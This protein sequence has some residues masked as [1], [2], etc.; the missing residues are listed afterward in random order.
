MPS[1]PPEV[2]IVVPARNAAPTLEG[3]LES[4]VAQTFGSWEAI[5]IDD[6]ST[7]AT[8]SLAGRYARGD[9][10]FSILPGPVRNLGSARNA[11][12]GKAAGRFLLFLDADDTIEPD[13]LA[14][15][16]EQLRLRSEADV[17]CWRMEI[18][19]GESHDFSRA[20]G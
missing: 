6:G 1:P 7:D 10:R 15:L 17:V 2:S 3:T 13:H 14:R 8:A 12:L 16:T 11:G 18:R 4:I 9:S 20:F 19:V 5:V